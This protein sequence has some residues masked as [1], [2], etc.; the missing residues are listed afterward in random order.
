MASERESPRRRSSSLRH[1]K[2][3]RVVWTPDDVLTLRPG[4][5]V[6]A[7][8]EFLEDNS[9]DIQD[10]MIHHGWRVLEELLVQAGIPE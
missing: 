8:A 10:E 2:Y 3:A 5:T 6:K 7:A 9:R 4:M 1:R